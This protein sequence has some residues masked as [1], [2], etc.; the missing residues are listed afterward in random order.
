M[1]KQLIIGTKGGRY[2]GRR[3]PARAGDVVD[4]EKVKS[5]KLTDAFEIQTDG[6]VLLK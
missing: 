4:A 6:T 3:R 1:A 5:I 2:I